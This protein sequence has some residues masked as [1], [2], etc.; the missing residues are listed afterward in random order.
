MQ[1]QLGYLK[2]RQLYL[3]GVDSILL[4]Q[5]VSEI[6]YFKQNVGA[7]LLIIFIGNPDVSKIGDAILVLSQGNAAI[8]SS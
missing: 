4:H 7:F 1:N 8:R 5:A 6:F 2:L 3:I